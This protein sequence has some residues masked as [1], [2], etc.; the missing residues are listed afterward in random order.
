MAFWSALHDVLNSARA[1]LPYAEEPKRIHWDHPDDEWKNERELEALE[2]AASADSDA[3]ISHYSEQHSWPRRSKN[4][5]RF[6]VE[7]RIRWAL[8]ITRLFTIPY[9]TGGAAIPR[10]RQ[11]GW[12]LLEWLLIKAY[13]HRFPPAPKVPFTIAGADG[14][15]RTIYT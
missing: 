9:A 6:F 10:P 11:S 4:N 5:A 3:L 1:S 2:D 8:G 12:E 7:K 14:T 15:L 13:H